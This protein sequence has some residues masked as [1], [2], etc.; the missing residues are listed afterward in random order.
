MMTL[1]QDAAN[2][3]RDLLL[4]GDFNLPEIS[5]IDNTVKNKYNE[6]F[7]T[8][9]EF[10]NCLLAGSLHQ[11]IDTA[12]RARGRDQPSL[13]DLVITN[14]EDNIEDLAV[15]APLGRSDHGIIQGNILFPTR[16]EE[17]KRKELWNYRKG[18]YL[19]ARNMARN[20]N[21]NEELAGKTSTEQYERFVEIMKTIRD[22]T[23]PKLLINQQTGKSKMWFNSSAERLVDKKNQAWGSYMR[24]E[25]LKLRERHILRKRYQRARQRARVG[26]RKIKRR[27]E[28]SLFL[29]IRDNPKSF[30]AYCNSS[31][32]IRKPVGKITLPDG[33]PAKDD[34]QAASVLSTHFK[35]VFTDEDD[36]NL[37]N[38]NEFFSQHYGDT[39]CPFQ[40]CHHYMGPFVDSVDIEDSEIASLLK[41]LK[42][43]KSPG[44]DDLHPQLLS[45]L[46]ETIAKPLGIIFRKSLAT[47]K[48]PN[49]WKEANIT[50]I[51]KKGPREDAK[52]Y[53]PISLTCIPSKIMETL[54]K[55][56]VMEHIS[57]MGILNDRQ[58]GFCNGRSCLTNLLTMTEDCSSNMDKKI[59]TDI[60]YLDFAKAFDTVPHARLCH[61]LQ[62][63]SGI[64]G[65]LLRWL[66]DFLTDRRQ[67]VVI[68][69]HFSA[70]ERVTSGVPQGSVIGPVLFLIYIN[71]LTSHMKSPVQIFADDTKLYRGIESDLDF[72]L[73]QQDLQQVEVW[74]KTWKL[75]YN[76]SKCQVLRIGRKQSLENRPTYVLNGTTL[77]NVL[78]QRDLGVMI[79]ASLE[80]DSHIN[81]SVKSAFTCWGIIKRTFEMPMKPKLFNLLYKTFIRCHLEYCPEVWSPLKIGAKKKIERVQRV[82][83]KRVKG[84]SHVSYEDRLAHLGLTTL[85]KRRERSDMV[86]VH[87]IV[88]KL[89]SVDLSAMFQLIPAGG[90]RGRYTIFKQRHRTAK[91]GASFS[92]RVINNWNKLPEIVKLERSST[93]FKRSYDK[94]V[95]AEDQD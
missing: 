32:K 21:W 28:E 22:A 24:A 25:R 10:M 93:S 33:T 53:R 69:G 14:W 2:L 43:F 58:H 5:W 86:E 61:K 27:H 37:I 81:K 62:H 49:Y 92:Q 41:Q 60:I 95:T 72:Q 47:G 4:V 64:T 19:K 15:T 65:D 91:R 87:R 57:S 1:L 9:V 8:P 88:H 73:L 67:R 52:N 56:K 90:R 50:A 11:H 40:D 12:T 68:S 77:D 3:S 36:A 78:E 94:T 55:V 35:S 46:A 54:V 26:I 16:K 83:T 51:H 38:C 23:V 31:N 76:T 6:G 48:V 30:Y 39:A 63:I 75:C 17:E 70:W 44:P 82:S 79:D 7:N 80:F 59:P 85:E 34:T 71:D 89:H 45:E 42:H 13:L 18:D 84:M 20:V 74:S 66:E 29:R